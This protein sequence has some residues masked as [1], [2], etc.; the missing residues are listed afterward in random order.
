MAKATLWHRLKR[1]T[2]ILG[3]G[4]VTGASDDDPSGIA[5]YSQTGAQFGYHQLWTMV[6]TIPLMI[7][8]Q[9][10]C[11]RIGLVSG[12]GI[13]G[14]IRKYYNPTI[15]WM[16]IA[17]LVAA[18]TVNLSANLGAMAAATQLLIPVPYKLTLLLVTLTSILLVIVIPYKIYANILKYLTLSLF[19]YVIATFSIH[20]D[21]LEIIR[22][23]LLP[24]I[25]TSSV[26]WLNIVAIMGTTISPYLFF[27]QANQEVE[28]E[29]NHKKL[30]IM[31]V[32]KPKITIRDIRHLRVDTVVGMIFSNLIALFIMIT[33]ASTLHQQGITMIT[34][35]PEAAA[36]LKPFAGE[37][38][39]MLFTLGIVGT[40]LLSI[41]VL[42]GS[43]AYALAEAF[44]QKEGLYRSLQKAKFF[45]GAIIIATLI[46]MTINFLHVEP[47]RLLYYAAIF[48]GLCTPPLLIMI[49]LIAN[50]RQIM[51]KHANSTWSNLGAVALTAL[52][53]AATGLLIWQVL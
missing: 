1:W 31:G 17:L 10:M 43:I 44:K 50:N 49:V 51:G 13:A 7:T 29:V 37:F 36:A 35:A 5:T 24:Q 15:L 25:G 39:S 6:L 4:F 46:A 11:G 38:A 40:G 41:P 2:S 32:G 42:A 22:H 19:A 30:R 8:I 3:P 12:K 45:Y 23:T 14:V 26:Y 9:E 28:E 33:T 21:W 47:F 53:T 16:V 34:S 18:N 27:W 52:M 20:Q 48:N